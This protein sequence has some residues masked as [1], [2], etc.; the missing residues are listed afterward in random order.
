MVELNMGVER[1][2]C[3]ASLTMALILVCLSFWSQGSG[4]GTL[5]QR[6]LDTYPDV[7]LVSSSSRSQHSASLSDRTWYGPQLL[8]TQQLLLRSS[9][10]SGQRGRCP[11]QGDCGKDRGRAARGELGR[12]RR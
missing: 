1:A 9:T 3:H 11:P 5:S 12:T 6:V 4:K 8:L 10:S 2:S 7:N